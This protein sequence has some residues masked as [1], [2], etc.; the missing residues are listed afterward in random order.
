MNERWLLASFLIGTH[1]LLEDPVQFKNLGLVVIDEQHSL[2]LRSG[3]PVEKEY[4]TTHVLV[5]TATLFPH[6]A[7]TIYGDLMYRYR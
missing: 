4:T 2:A 3:G 1:A 7:M 5:M 6:L